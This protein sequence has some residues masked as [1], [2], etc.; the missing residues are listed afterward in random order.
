MAINKREEMDRIFA[1]YTKG[2]MDVATA[3]KELKNAGIGLNLDPHKNSLTPAEIMGAVGGDKP[4]GFGLMDDGIGLYKAEAKNGKM[5]QKTFE[6][7]EG[8]NVEFKPS[9]HWFFIAGEK[10]FVS[11]KDGETLIRQ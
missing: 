7:P 3:N 6:I 11:D 8:W 4:T 10:Y 1:A 2:E 9:N 5:T